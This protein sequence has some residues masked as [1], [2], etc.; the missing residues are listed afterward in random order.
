MTIKKIHSRT[1]SQWLF[2]DLDP[3]PY[4]RSPRDL[5]KGRKKTAKARAKGAASASSSFGDDAFTDPEKIKAYEPTDEERKSAFFNHYGMTRKQYSLSRREAM[6]VKEISDEEKA[7][8]AQGLRD[9][10]AQGAEATV[11]FLDQPKAKT[12]AAKEFL[13]SGLEDGSATDDIVPVQETAIAANALQPTQ[14]FIDFAKSIA[15]PCSIYDAFQKSMQGGPTTPGSRI[16]V[17]VFHGGSDGKTHIVLDG[18]HRWS[19]IAIVNPDCLI[20]CRVIKFDEALPD[21][22]EPKH[23]LAKAQVAVAASTPVG[24]KLPGKGG[25]PANNILGNISKQAMLDLLDKE[26]GNQLEGSGPVF[27]GD[28]WIESFLADGPSVKMVFPQDVPQPLSTAECS[29]AGSKCPVRKGIFEYLADNWIGGKYKQAPGTP[30]RREMMP[31]LDHDA[32]GGADG[33]GTMRDRLSKGEIQVNPVQES[34][35][36]M[37]G[38]NNKAIITETKTTQSP[39]E[40]IILKRWQ[41]LSGVE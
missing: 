16:S 3:E 7:E 12:A 6:A 27:M 33:F 2:E 38:I 37:A 23:L 1:I 39:N 9:A 20:N 41:K 31:Q 22:K 40:N 36:R 18:H 30:K 21:L 14:G 4:L 28:Q 35:A 24:A 25:N 17:A 8:L 19:G 34:W 10:I 32:L 11:A 15:Y 26:V 5:E 29:G 13:G